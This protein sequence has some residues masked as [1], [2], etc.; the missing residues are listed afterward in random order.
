MARPVVGD[1]V[2]GWFVSVGV[3]GITDFVYRYKRDDS[4]ITTPSGQVMKIPLILMSLAENR[5]S[6][7]SIRGTQP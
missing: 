7:V 6:P 4:R 5:S 2:G 1:G 3:L